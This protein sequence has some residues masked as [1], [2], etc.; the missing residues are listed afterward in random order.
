MAQP[1]GIEAAARRSALV[2][3]ALDVA[4]QAHSDQIRSGSGGRPYIDHPVAVAECL[5]ERGFADEVLTAALLHDVVEDSELTV[6]DIRDRFGEWIAE[7]VRILS[8]DALIEPYE[9]RKGEHRDRVAAAGP[10]ALAI[11]AADKLTNVSML[12]SAYEREGEGAGEDLQVSLDEKFETWQR[13][14]EMLLRRAPELSLVNDL[15]NQL[16]ALASDRDRAAEA[17]PPST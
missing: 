5:A 11:Y 9:L 1:A 17:P 4:R 6:E 3:E 10:E 13:D 2:R 16:A 7:L 8:E 14:L 12:R 15:A